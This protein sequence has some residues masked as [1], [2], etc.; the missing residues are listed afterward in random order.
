M[1]AIQ[2]IQDLWFALP[3]Q[4]REVIV[5]V[6]QILPLTVTVILCVAFLT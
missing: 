1:A 5:I 3:D 6:V 4:L 2:F